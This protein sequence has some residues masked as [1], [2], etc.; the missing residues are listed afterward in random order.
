MIACLFVC[1]SVSP[2]N[3]SITSVDE[4]GEV[5]FSVAFACLSVCLSVQ[6]ITQDRYC[7]S[8][9]PDVFIRVYLFAC[10]FVC[11]FVSPGMKLER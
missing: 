8:V 1:L 2:D 10:L 7:L 3:N 9:S 6:T 11:L 5:V 4:I